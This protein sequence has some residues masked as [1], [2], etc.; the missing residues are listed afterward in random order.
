VASWKKWHLKVR[1]VAFVI[2]H[3]THRKTRE[4]EEYIEG[5]G[6]NGNQRKGINQKSWE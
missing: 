1:N 3:P 4:R 2:E 6:E 5:T